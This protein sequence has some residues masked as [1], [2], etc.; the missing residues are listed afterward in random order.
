MKKMNN[1]LV[2]LN[3]ATHEQLFIVILNFHKI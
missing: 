3:P 1:N 2:P